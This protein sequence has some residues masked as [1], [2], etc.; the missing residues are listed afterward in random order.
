M[1]SA[2]QRCPRCQYPVAPGAA[3]CSNCGLTLAAPAQRPYGAEPLLPPPPPT[4]PYGGTGYGGTGYDFTNQ[5]APGYP[6]SA[7]AYGGS[8]PAYPGSQPQRGFGAP[9]YPG[10]PP[11]TPSA[12]PAQKGGSGLKIAIIVLV[13]LVVLGGGGGVAAYLLT[14]PKPTITV[15]SDYK[16]GTTPVGATSTVFT[17]SGQKFSGN[18]TITFLL[19]NKP[20]PDA[21]TALSDGNGNI[22]AKL[23][24]SANWG[25]GPHTL[26]AKDASN[27]TTQTGVTLII[28]NQGE[29]HTPGPNGAPTDSGSFSVTLSITPQDASTGGALTPFKQELMVQGQAQTGQQICDTNP[30]L[31][32]G[33]PHS[34]SGT[35]K[36]GTKYNETY[37]WKCTGTYKGGKFSYTET[38]VSDTV[39]YANGITCK[40]STPYV[41]TQLDG[42]FTA[43]TELSG[44]YSADIINYTCSDKTTLHT[45]PEKGTLTGTLIG[46]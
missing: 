33:Q 45:D 4:G 26:T 3:A 34:Y 29:N 13:V 7:P 32:D 22:S 16:N 44:T 40:A 10:A 39:A 12:P 11:F 8:A 19:D 31:D 42:T 28:V 35:D 25:V 14:R 21:Q 24:V 43:A 5:P 17:V 15:N 9:A 27:Y 41:W 2:D 36:N 46:S 1:Y 30:H 18:S 6:G 37:I 38:S 20:A 23:T